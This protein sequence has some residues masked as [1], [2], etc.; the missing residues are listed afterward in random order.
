MNE[1]LATIPAAREWMSRNFPQADAIF[2][3]ALAIWLHDQIAAAL[4]EK[5]QEIARLKAEIK[6]QEDSL[7]ICRMNRDGYRERTE[8]A[9]K[10]VAEL[11]HVFGI[12]AANA[13]PNVERLQKRAAAGE[14][15]AGAL[16]TVSLA[17][18]TSPYPIDHFDEARKVASAA[19][20][21][22]EEGKK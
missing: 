3:D 1:P 16:Q 12:Q 15:L 9:E 18:A 14:A 4:R 20:S 5:E 19:I 7:A 13:E 22:W 21:A 6:A 17:I 10:R 11:E 8:A 2:T